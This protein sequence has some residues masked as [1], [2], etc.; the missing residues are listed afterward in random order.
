MGQNKNRIF[1]IPMVKV[2][3]RCSTE[4]PRRKK[5]KS[6]EKEKVRRRLIARSEMRP[7]I[8][9]IES[10][11]AEIYLFEKERERTRIEQSEIEMSNIKLEEN[12]QELRE[13]LEKETERAARFEFANEMLSESLREMTE[14]YQK[15]KSDYEAK[16]ARLLK[17][18]QEIKAKCDMEKKEFKQGMPQVAKTAKAEITR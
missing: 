17:E 10:L 8:T 18:T 12:L 4:F 3:N 15:L 7:F 14:D 1:K 6:S 5:R 11:K 13:K 2:P 9:Q 16:T